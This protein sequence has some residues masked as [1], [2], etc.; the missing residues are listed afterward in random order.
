VVEETEYDDEAK[1]H[2]DGS[3]ATGN[4]RLVAELQTKYI[5]GTLEISIYFLFS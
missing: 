5:Q 2:A 1:N 4:K 3:I